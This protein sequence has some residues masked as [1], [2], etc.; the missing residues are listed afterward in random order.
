MQ[1]RTGACKGLW[2][3]RDWC[4]CVWME[5]GMDVVMSWEVKDHCPAGSFLCPSLEQ[6]RSVANSNPGGNVGGDVLCIMCVYVFK[7]V[8]VWGG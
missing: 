2:G 8:G 5:R 1:R 6:H 7:R 3:Q 4:V